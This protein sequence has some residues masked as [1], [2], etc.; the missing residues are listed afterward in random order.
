MDME[1][2]RKFLVN[3]K[4]NL[5]DLSKYEKEEITQYYLFKN[6]EMRI[7]K[8]G[9]KFYVTYKG[10]GDL[11][12]IEQ[13]TD[14][15]PVFFEKFKDYCKGQVIYKTRYKIPLANSLVAEVDFYHSYLKGLRIVEIEFDSVEQANAFKDFPD[16]FGEEVTNNPK[17]KNKN[18]SRLK[19]KPR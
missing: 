14:V 5:M 17:Y 12:R 8:C 2:E 13:E 1:I 10:A 6:P 9:E 3:D 4:I 19:R 7:R 15:S 18:L 11:Q 16:F